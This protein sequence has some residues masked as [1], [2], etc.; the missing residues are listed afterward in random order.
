MNVVVSVSTNSH[1]NSGSISAAGMYASM[2]RSSCASVSSCSIVRACSIEKSPAR[3]RTSFSRNAPQPTSLP[4]S[5]ASAR[6]Y[7]PAEQCT[8]IRASAPLHSPSSIE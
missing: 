7:V 6:R 5:F 2:K 3:S 1:G 4:R 8:T